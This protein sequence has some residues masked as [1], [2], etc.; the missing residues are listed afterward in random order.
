MKPYGCHNRQ[1]EA[2]YMVKDGHCIRDCIELQIVR[3]HKDTGT[4]ECQYRKE[5]LA[6]PRC[7]GCKAP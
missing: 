7:D 2:G 6:D 5:T 1:P 3:Y 4:K